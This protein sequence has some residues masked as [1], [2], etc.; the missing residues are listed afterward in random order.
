MKEFS[1]QLSEWCTWSVWSALPVLT[2][3]AGVLSQGLWAHLNFSCRSGSPIDFLA[4]HGRESPVTSSLL[5]SQYRSAC[6]D[7]DYMSRC[8]TAFLRLLLSALAMKVHQASCS[9]HHFAYLLAGWAI[10]LTQLGLSLALVRL[11]V[12][13]FHLHPFLNHLSETRIMATSNFHISKKFLPVHLVFP[14]H[15]LSYVTRF[16][17]MKVTSSLPWSCPLL[18]LHLEHLQ[19]LQ[20]HQLSQRTQLLLLP[21]PP[22]LPQL[23]L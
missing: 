18:R 17:L 14:H 19:H 4:F 21:H 23:P 11:Q 16:R 2:L 12:C 3:S 1:P 9:L 13:H 7:R 5:S 8:L 6:F 22:L 15:L 10:S 20:G